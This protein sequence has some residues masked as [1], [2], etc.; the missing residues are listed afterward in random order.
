[1]KQP[2]LR[3]RTKAEEN[4][5]VLHA[6]SLMMQSGR[7][8]S[9]AESFTGGLIASQIVNLPGAS[10]FF[11]E[12]VVAYGDDAKIARLGVQAE[13]IKQYSSVSVECAYEMA[14]GLLSD[15]NADIVIATTGYAGPAAPDP[16]LLGSCCL[17]IGDRK[18]LHIYKFRFSGGRENIM[19]S[20]MLEA[21]SL[22]VGFLLG[23][24][25]AEETL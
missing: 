19:R 8:L 18:N 5:L 3:K 13:T 7:K 22:L 25:E 2:A 16:A 1:M 24:G 20:G 11:Y 15:P 6:F 9:V 21:F 17:A 23:T 12:G 14:L 4:E 10:R